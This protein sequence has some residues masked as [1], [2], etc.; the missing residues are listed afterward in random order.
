MALIRVFRQEKLDLLSD[1]TVAII[2]LLTV[3]SALAVVSLTVLALLQSDYWCITPVVVIYLTSGLSSSVSNNIRYI[4][5]HWFD[6][7]DIDS[8]AASK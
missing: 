5:P 3:I 2:I 8:G 1:R 6:H 7:T 4:M